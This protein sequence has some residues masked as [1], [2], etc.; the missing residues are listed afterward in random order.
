MAMLDPTT[1]TVM[2]GKRRVGFSSLSGRNI[3]PFYS[4]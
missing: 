3:N 1:R 2:K 4:S